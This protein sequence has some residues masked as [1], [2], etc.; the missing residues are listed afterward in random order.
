[1]G[2][3][4]HLSDL[5]LAQVGD[6]NRRYGQNLSQ[7][8]AQ[9][10]YA[11]VGGQPFLVRQALYTL[12]ARHWSLG[13]LQNQALA[14]ESPFSDHLRRIGW[15]LQQAPRLRQA[16]LQILCDGNCDDELDF[17][18]LCA[19]GLVAG[20]ARNQARLRCQLYEQYFRQGL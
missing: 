19:A 9:Q 15:R 13:E 2:F 14:A 4:I 1:M 18:R 8:E 10:L 6:L 7:A 17:Q 5:T 3:S 20:S 16:A 11:L 12:H